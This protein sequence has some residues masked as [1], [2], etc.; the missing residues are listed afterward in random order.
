V[1]GHAVEPAA[2]FQCRY[3]V[4]TVSHPRT[5]WGFVA[6]LR[7]LQMHQKVSTQPSQPLPERLKVVIVESSEG[8]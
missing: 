5:N 6:V 4:R 8:R 2:I 3:N 1:H 7:G